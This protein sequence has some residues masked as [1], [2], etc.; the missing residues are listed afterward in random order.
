[1]ALLTKQLSSHL[2]NVN[3]IDENTVKSLIEMQSIIENLLS[4][5][6]FCE[7][8]TPNDCEFVGD[9]NDEYF[10][11]G[12]HIVCR[13]CHVSKLFSFARKKATNFNYRSKF[14]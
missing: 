8:E 1:M 2:K 5:S 11:L 3:R 7:A 9:L 10:E 13:L 12:R 14:H 6:T 4:E